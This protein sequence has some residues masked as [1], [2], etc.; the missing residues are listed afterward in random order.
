MLSVS[1]LPKG[2]SCERDVSVSLDVSCS[3][4]KVR[5]EKRLVDVLEL[6]QVVFVG[7]INRV[8]TV[9]GIR[10]TTSCQDLF[11]ELDPDPSDEREHLE[12]VAVDVDRLLAVAVP[13]VLVDRQV[14]VVHR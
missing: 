9:G 14:N 8:P 12:E 2:A 6:L 3:I 1:R 5:D 11:F 4:L 10:Q 13:I 7:G